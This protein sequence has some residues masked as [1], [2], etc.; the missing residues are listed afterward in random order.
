M[1]L[2]KPA[3]ADGKEPQ[4]PTTVFADS[5]ATDSLLVRLTRLRKRLDEDAYANALVFALHR[6]LIL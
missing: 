6:P 5:S 4:E 1:F 3:K 2:R